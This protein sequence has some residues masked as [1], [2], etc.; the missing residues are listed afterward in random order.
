[1]AGLSP[2]VAGGIVWFLDDQRHLDRHQ[3]DQSRVRYREALAR[4]DPADVRVLANRS[5]PG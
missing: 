5:I 1:V 2:Q 3:T 4:L